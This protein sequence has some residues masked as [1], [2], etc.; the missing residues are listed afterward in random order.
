LDH[1]CSVGGFLLL[2]ELFCGLE[3]LLQRSAV[4]FLLAQL[5]L[6]F[7][8][9]LLECSTGSCER[10]VWTLLQ[11]KQMFKQFS[12]LLYKLGVFVSD[13]LLQLDHQLFQVSQPL[14]RLLGSLRLHWSLVLTGREL[15]HQHTLFKETDKQHIGRHLPTY[16]LDR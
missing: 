4:G 6:K 15:R 3:S 1:L 10:A 11:T 7:L 13:E 2:K 12:V 9:I 8:E 16:S 5:V 14:H